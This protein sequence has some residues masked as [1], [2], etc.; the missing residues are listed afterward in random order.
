[1]KQTKEF[2][3]EM[4]ISEQNSVVQAILKLTEKA[5]NYEYFLI[6]SHFG[7]ENVPY[8]NIKN[9]F[10]LMKEKNIKVSKSVDQY[11]KFFVVKPFKIEHKEGYEDVA[12]K[13]HY[14]IGETISR[15][16][17][18]SLPDYHQKNIEIRTD[19]EL[20]S[21]EI[22][23]SNTKVIANKVIQEFPAVAKAV[24][25]RL[26]EEEKKQLY[27]N[28]A[29]LYETN[30][31]YIAVN[32][33]VIG[34]RLI[35]RATKLSIDE[36]KHLNKEQKKNFIENVDKPYQRFIE[37]SSRYKTKDILFNDLNAAM[38]S[39]HGSEEY[40]KIIDL[41]ESTEGAFLE[42]VN[43]EKGIIVSSALNAIA[44]GKI[45]GNKTNHC[46]SGFDNQ[47]SFNSTVKFGYKQFLIVN[48]GLKPNE[49][50]RIIGMT[51]DNKGNVTRAHSKSDVD[52]K[53]HIHNILLKWNIA[54]YIRPM[55]EG[56]IIDSLYAGIAND[57]IFTD[58]DRCDMVIQYLPKLD[59]TKYDRKKL[60]N[61]IRFTHKFEE[62]RKIVRDSLDM[63]DSSKF[64][65]NYDYLANNILKLISDDEQATNIVKS[66]VVEYNE[67]VGITKEDALVML[68]NKSK[69]VLPNRLLEIIGE[70]K[71]FEYCKSYD[72]NQVCTIL[73]FV[74][75]FYVLFLRD[76][77]NPTK[78][79]ITKVLHAMYEYEQ[80]KDIRQLLLIQMFITGQLERVDKAELSFL[81][82]KINAD[83]YIP[84]DVPTA[85]DIKRDLEKIR[86]FISGMK[87]TVDHKLI[88]DTS[89]VPSQP[90]L[91]VD[92]S[93]PRYSIEL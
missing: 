10:T 15:K 74:P 51:I 53:P 81:A 47:T 63:D 29:N 46:I 32:P 42:G 84:A 70:D 92:D 11:V 91:P 89:K 8:E 44:Y 30:F 28:L 56:E 54:Q 87:F 26:T 24:V 31:G 55:D 72:E 19:F 25:D 2:L 93:K 14:V 65:E 73:E 43:V 66:F 80:R 17:Y 13:T 57:T 1:M 50:N 67:K 3:K 23:D 33:I 90:I 4:G 76:I 34:D 52:V 49:D 68:I 7:R 61:F 82:S 35:E 37:K 85:D 77:K 71:F 39:L 83:T 27:F 18:K 62:M 45:G 86:D 12:G 59:P 6:K 88:A 79:E 21:D 69:F 38:Y 36:Y 41:V 64:L 5:P 16:I 9:T 22:R 48:T 58:R 20:F 75:Q 78:L 40:K 60:L